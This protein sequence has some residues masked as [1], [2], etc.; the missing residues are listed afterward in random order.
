[1]RR[2]QVHRKTRETD[3]TVVVGLEGGSVC[4]LDTGVG[5]LDHMLEQVA[6]HGLFDLEV[7]AEGDLHIDDHHTV[8]D[9]ALA[10]GAAFREALGDCRGIRRFASL[11]QP[12]DEALVRVAL[13]ISGRSHLSWRVTMPTG[14][15]GS[16][17]T[18]LVG[19][20]FKAFCSAAGLTLHVDALAGL[21]SHHLAEACFKGLGRALREAVALDPAR[22]TQIPSSKGSL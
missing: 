9:T 8:E 13:D 4:A 16:F 18:E 11:E 17:D 5:F 6:R 15:I 14:K 1:M 21:N 12:M 10:L 19:E 20:W 7:K 2:A 22:G 3:I